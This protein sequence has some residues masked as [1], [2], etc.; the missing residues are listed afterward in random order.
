MVHSKVGDVEVV[1][2]TLKKGQK[3]SL[4]EKDNTQ[5]TGGILLTFLVLNVKK[6][7]VIILDFSNI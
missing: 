1:Q 2:L 3:S 6:A 5:K 4:T 7:S